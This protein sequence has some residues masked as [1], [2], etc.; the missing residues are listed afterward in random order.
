MVKDVQDLLSSKGIEF[1]ISGKDVLIKCL[2]PEHPDS[3]PSLRVD[4]LTGAAH[5]FACGFRANI[6]TFFGLTANTHSILT[7]KIKDKIVKIIS[8]SLGLEMPKG[9]QPYTREY[10]GIRAETLRHFEAFTHK[11]YE[12][13]IV[14]PLR[15]S[16]GKISCF[17]GRHL[18]NSG[19][20]RYKVYPSNV[21]VPLFPSRVE[22]HDGSVVL[23]E[24]TFDMMNL[25]D[26]GIRNVVAVM[27]TQNFGSI[28]GLNKDK[29][30]NL[31]LQGI[32]KIWFLFDGDAAGQKAVELL[33]PMVEAAGFITEVIE[34]PEDSDPGSLS[35][36]D[37]KLLKGILEK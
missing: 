10:R 37:I 17:V 29:V 9:Y 1:K 20:P 25:Y 5:C 12:D 36:E 34:L 33:K 22:E 8:E 14:F 3:N 18:L 23:V 21:E 30:L 19:T 15:D 26:K 16:K 11:D 35:K 13:R 4:K 2:N 6:Y 7:T 27:G 24:G 31:K 32:R 28:K